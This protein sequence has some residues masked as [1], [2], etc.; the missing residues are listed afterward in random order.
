MNKL[1]QCTVIALLVMGMVGCGGNNEKSKEA[2]EKDTISVDSGAINEAAFLESMMDSVKPEASQDSTKSEESTVRRFPTTES[3][4]SYMKQSNHWDQY[5]KG[6][7]PT[8]AQ[9]VPSYC[10]KILQSPYDNFIIVDKGKMKLFLYDKY[11]NIVHSC[12]IACGRNYGTKSGSWDSKT[13]EG[14]F[15][16]E[17]VYDSRMWPFINQWG[18][19]SGPGVF[20]PWFIRVQGSIGIH[21]TSSPGS[22][23]HR[24][25]HGCIR[26]TNENINKIKT[27]ARAGMPIIVSPGPRDM[28]ANKAAGINIPS[29]TTETGTARAVPGKADE[30]AVAAQVKKAATTEKAVKSNTSVKETAPAPESD[31]SVTPETP[32]ESKSE[33]TTTPKEKESAPA[34]TKEPATT[35]ALAPAPAPAAPTGD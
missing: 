5:S 23:G 13:V 35:P 1:S 3:Q 22:I 25:S 15:N 24:V 19:R 17:G 20:G 6:I 7:L 21:G 4:L 27:Y 10:E 8:M 12:G 28:A 11:G 2:N 14:I 29:V 26:V 34:G 16:A 9:E 32:K 30:A 31:H 18:G 33:S